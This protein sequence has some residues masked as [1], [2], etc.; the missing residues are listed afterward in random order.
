VRFLR[1]A[2]C[3][4]VQGFFYGEAVPPAQ[5]AALLSRTTSARKRA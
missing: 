2:G 1:R 4:E 5:H 3:D